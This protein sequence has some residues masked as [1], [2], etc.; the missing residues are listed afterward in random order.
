MLKAARVIGLNSDQEAAISA[1]CENDSG[2]KLFMVISCS[3]D[4]A[5]TRVRQAISETEVNFFASTSEL[6]Q[7][8]LDS[9]DFI[10]EYLK[11]A[12]DLQILLASSEGGSSSGSLLYLVYQ[13][14]RVSALLLRNR[15]NV[16][17]CSLSKE[18]QMISGFIKP[19]DKIVL[20]TNNLLNLVNAEAITKMNV[21]TFEEEVI[22][23]LA[24]DNPLPL[25]AILI[26]E[27]LTTPKPQPIEELPREQI[28][29]PRNLNLS[30]LS[31]IKRL[32]PRSV[33]SL[34]VV[35]LLLV[36][37]MALGAF[38]FSKQKK[39]AQ[40]LT[41]FNQRL[42]KA[43][44]EYSKALSLKDSDTGLA[45][46]SL[47]L[48]KSDLTE[49]LK[50]LP[51]DKKA[52]G[53][54]KQLEDSKADIMKVYI[55]EPFLWLD[56][57]LIKE[58][59]KGMKMSYF[60]QK[61]LL[62]D[63]N[64]KTLVAI[65]LLTKSPE[66]LAGQEKLGEAQAASIY[67]GVAWVLSDNGIL[68]VDNKSHQVST[69]VKKDPQ[70]GD[71]LGIESFGSNLYLLDSKGM[72]WK[73][74]PIVSGFADKANYFKGGVSLAGAKLFR[75]DSSVYI[76]AGEKM[77][78]FTQGVTDNLNLTGLDKPLNF[79]VS[80]FVSSD[81]DNLYVL[82]SGNARLVVFA[83]DGKYKSQ[84]LSDKF[85]S[86]SD[87]VVDEKNKK[88]FFLDSSKIDQIDLK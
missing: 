24:Q 36:I 1:V 13:G 84:Y 83:K 26:E 69:V 86:Y 61:T 40:V 67:D 30:A 47:G 21:E 32:R 33:K 29:Q 68:K 72:I 22:G 49:A 17:L 16:N 70:W 80:F 25:A 3:L 37:L 77:A 5:F 66:I 65:N 85:K 42:Q 18:G 73:Y 48:A 9:L 79:P 60:D 15:E 87:L 28:S 50:I 62:L 39:D 55:V 53:L 27:E 20:L 7:K 4:D 10:K 34:A 14:D 59:F 57:N 82:D 11:D 54:Q 75:I 6:S 71:I 74:V 56:L 38:Y 46:E 43:A 31:F 12:Y 64:Q 23:L 8:L 52:Q 45:M 2:S 41:A 88:V 76:L 35:V 81:T 78:K 51:Q 19:R 58:G 63:T 44:E